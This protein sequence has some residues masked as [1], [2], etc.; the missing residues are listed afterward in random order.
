[1]LPRGM[2]FGAAFAEHVL[3][4]IRVQYRARQRPHRNISNPPIRNGKRSFDVVDEGKEPSVI[5]G[6][7]GDLRAKL[8]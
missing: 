1:M 3:T 5:V 6:H 7:L 2:A 8:S 4:E